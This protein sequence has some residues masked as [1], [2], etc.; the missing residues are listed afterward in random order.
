MWL[1]LPLV[2]SDDW[3][4]NTLVKSQLK[5]EGVTPLVAS[6]SCAVFLDDS[7]SGNA[8]FVQLVDGY[9]F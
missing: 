8:Y 2:L 1:G 3:R 5:E 4:D 6:R 9:L 7:E